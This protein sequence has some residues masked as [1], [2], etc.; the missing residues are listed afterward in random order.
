MRRGS[1]LLALGLALLAGAVCRAGEIGV[2][3]LPPEAT[4]AGTPITAAEAAPATAPTRPATPGPVE[5]FAA[6]ALPGCCGPCCR[7]GHQR[8]DCLRKLANWLSYCPPK[9]ACCCNLGCASC[10]GGCCHC[11]PCCMPVYMYFLD[12]CS[13]T[14]GY[15]GPPPHPP[16]LPPDQVPIGDLA[17]GGESVPGAATPGGPAVPASGTPAT[18]GR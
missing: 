14:L 5:G 8:G 12:R 15:R 2:A 4:P 11:T 1:T 13:C 7:V 10:G 9:V 6:A 3:Q 16:L 17:P 18:T